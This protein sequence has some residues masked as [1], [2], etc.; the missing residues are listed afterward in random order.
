MGK[1]NLNKITKIILVI[2]VLVVILIGG[3]F[4]WQ[5]QTAYGGK[6]PPETWNMFV[7]ALKKKDVE[8]AIKY[9]DSARQK[10]AREWLDD[11]ISK[12]QIDEMVKDLSES[13]LSELKKEKDMA[14]YALGKNKGEIYANIFF[15][16]N[17]IED[18]WKILYFEF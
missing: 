14:E 8:L 1:V 3:Y 9:F 11:A 13:N 6:T 10:K 5:K 2:F 15:T 18:I 16:R 17:K 4:F 7:E 12:N